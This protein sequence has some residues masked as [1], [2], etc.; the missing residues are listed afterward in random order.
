MWGVCA[1][2][3]VS[4]LGLGQSLLRTEIV[5]QPAVWVAYKGTAE[6]AGERG[7]K[8]GGGQR[9]GK[10]GGGERGEREREE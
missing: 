2:A 3:W 10:E 6:V 1:R 7:G 5:S 4:V 8:E 9:G